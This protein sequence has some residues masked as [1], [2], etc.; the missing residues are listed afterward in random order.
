MTVTQFWREIGVQAAVSARAEE[1]LREKKA[2]LSG[3]PLERWR[4]AP[5]EEGLS[6]RRSRRPRRS[7]PR[8]PPCS[9]RSSAI[10]LRAAK[11]AGQRA[12]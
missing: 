11:W 9:G 6:A 1:V 12:F 7:C 5:Y 4:T 10:C 3:L 8:R 2:L